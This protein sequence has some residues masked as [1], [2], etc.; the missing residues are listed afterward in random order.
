MPVYAAPANPPPPPS[1]AA[2]TAQMDG[3]MTLASTEGTQSSTAWQDWYTALIAGG[4]TIIIFGGVTYYCRDGVL[5]HWNDAAK[6]FFVQNTPL[7][8]LLF[9]GL[10]PEHTQKK[11]SRGV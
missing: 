1:P 5:V 9:N 6:P 7:R 4:V 11:K 3:T 2:L 8:L 10:K